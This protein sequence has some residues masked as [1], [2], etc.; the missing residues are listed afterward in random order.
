MQVKGQA[1]GTSLL[2]H[3]DPSPTT[4]TAERLTFAQHLTLNFTTPSA[5][6]V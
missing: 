2:S 5:K 4:K 1:T 6:V 3:S